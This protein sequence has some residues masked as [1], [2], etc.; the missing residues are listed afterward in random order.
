MGAYSY[1]LALCCFNYFMCPCTYEKLSVVSYLRFNNDWTQQHVKWLSKCKNQQCGHRNCFQESLEYFLEHHNINAKCWLF[2]HE[3]N[4]VDP[5]QKDAKCSQLP[6]PTIK[7]RIVKVGEDK[8]DGSNIEKPFNQ[9][10]PG[11]EVF[12]GIK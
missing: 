1:Q 5:A 9:V 10:Y 12:T 7:A 6:S 2:T 11:C 3:E 8:N 4:E